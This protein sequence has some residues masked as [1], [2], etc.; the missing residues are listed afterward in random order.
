MARFM[1]FSYLVEQETLA[2]EDSMSHF[3]KKIL[4]IA[5]ASLMAFVVGCSHAEKKSDV[6]VNQ[7]TTSAPAPVPAPSTTADVQHHDHIYGV[8]AFPKGQYALSELAKERLAAMCRDMKARGQ[9]EHVKA[10]VWSDKD[11]PSNDQDL[12]KNDL[13]LADRRAEAIENFLDD[14]LDV[15]SVTSYNMA[16]RSSWLARLFNT[17]D[18]E[19]K[20]LFS[21]RGATEISDEDFYIFKNEG[22]PSRA[23]VIIEKDMR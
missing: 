1:L 11:L 7:P 6:A 14:E 21:V 13:K 19:L 3:D 15:T 18:A 12:S 23:V 17:G 5:C 8:V 16:K 20:S 10:A 9:I 22:G 4:L 2:K